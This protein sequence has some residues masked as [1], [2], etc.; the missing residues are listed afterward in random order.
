M[1]YM[2]GRSLFNQ[3]YE[4]TVF[5]LAVMKIVFQPKSRIQ[6]GNGVHANNFKTH[7]KLLKLY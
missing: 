7:Q 5:F 6:G 3:K 4:K 1:L 2:F